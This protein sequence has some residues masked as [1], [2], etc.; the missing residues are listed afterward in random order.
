MKKTVSIVILLFGMLH[1]ISSQQLCTEL[2]TDDVAI[3]KDMF[4]KEGICYITLDVV[5]I[6]E[7]EHDE[8]SHIVN[9]NPKLR[10]FII[11][12]EMEWEICFPDLKKVKMKDVVFML[13]TIKET[14]IS[15]S[16]KN[17][18][19]VSSWHYSCAG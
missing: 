14:F 12:P 18:R 7:N 8:G 3:I 11:D 1:S 16:A 13:D 5:Q 4:V 15:Y 17:G 19:I 2:R 10:T 6:I 9:E